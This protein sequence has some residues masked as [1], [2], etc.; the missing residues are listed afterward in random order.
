MVAS[1]VS[2]LPEVVGDAGILVDPHDADALCQALLDVYRDAGLRERM[3]ERS[4]ARAA[5]FSW[6]RCTRQTLDA[7]RTALAA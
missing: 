1:G 6:E 3:R 5:T 7:Y 4:L 2:S